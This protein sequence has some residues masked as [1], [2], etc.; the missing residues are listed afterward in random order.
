MVPEKFVAANWIFFFLKSVS[1]PKSEPN[2]E[3]K[4]YRRNR[5]RNH[6]R[7]SLPNF[8][9]QATLNKTIAFLIF[10]EGKVEQVWQKSS[11]RVGGVQFSNK[12]ISR[13]TWAAHLLSKRSANAW[14]VF[15]IWTKPCKSIW[16]SILFIRIE[17]LHFAWEVLTFWKGAQNAAQVK[18]LKP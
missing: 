2:T 13:H 14:E 4:K 12:D 11:K 9:W 18:I 3:P 10:F 1:E 16:F 17:T 8:W 15:A 5:R 7:N 6:C